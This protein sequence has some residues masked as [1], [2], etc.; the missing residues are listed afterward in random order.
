MKSNYHAEA[1]VAGWSGTEKP[2][3]VNYLYRRLKF[4]GI[5]MLVT[6]VRLARNLRMILQVVAALASWW[7]AFI[8]RFEGSLPANTLNQFLIGLPIVAGARLFTYYAFGLHRRMWRYT[9]TKDLLTLAYSVALGSFIIASTVWFLVHGQANSRSVYIIDFMF[10]LSIVAGMR[11]LVRVAKEQHATSATRRQRVLIVGAGDTGELIVREMLRTPEK[12]FHPVAFADDDFAKSRHR[13]H[14]IPVLGGIAE[15]PDIVQQKEIDE[16]VIAIPSAS[17]KTLRRIFKYCRM[18][19]AESKALPRIADIIAGNV[20]INN[21]RK[22]GVEDLLGRE[23]VNVNL[24][25]IS[26]YLKGQSILVTGAGGSIG[27]EI[28]RQIAPYEPSK[29]VLVDYDENAIFAISSELKATPKNTEVISLVLDI[30][31]CKSME[32]VFASHQPSV[33]F[34]AAAHKHVPLMENQALEAIRNNVLGTMNVISLSRRHGVK[35]IVNISTDKAVEPMNIMGMTK[36]VGELI[37]HA[38]NDDSSASSFV[39]VRFGNVLGSAGSVI[40]TFKEQ[41]ANGGPVTVTHPDMERYFMTI[42]EAVQLVIQSGAFGGKGEIYILDMGQ[43]VKISKLAEDLI[44]LSGFKPGEDIEIVYTGSRPGE[45]MTERLSWDG[46]EELS[47][48]SHARIM[49]AKNNRHLLPRDLLDAVGELIELTDD[50][51]E[52]QALAML[53]KLA[54]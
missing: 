4:G 6:H 44:R 18:S 41:I 12:G 8:V 52:E 24:D 43:P 42:Q 3:Y 15:I 14:N 13:I 5:E 34:H 20:T 25:E 19:S 35:S 51:K 45:K 31:N 54:G 28:C 29:L 23:P 33:V 1:N 17:G 47:T 9:G 10:H 48:T 49:V 22:V 16:I 11:F 40:P 38:A 36:R 53:R 21:I 39:S 37:V 46:K 26:G 7:L 27:S 2:G 32:R 30:L 50:Q